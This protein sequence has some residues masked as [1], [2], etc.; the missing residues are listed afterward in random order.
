M[1]TTIVEAGGVWRNHIFVADFFFDT[2]VFEL[3]LVDGV[4]LGRRFSPG[5]NLIA[6]GIFN[7]GRAGCLRF[8]FA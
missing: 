8:F 7:P 2:Q 4:R 3:R 6:I 5:R 1:G